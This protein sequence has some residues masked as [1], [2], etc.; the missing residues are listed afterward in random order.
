ML[1]GWDDLQRTFLL[2][3]AVTEL[4][5]EACFGCLQHFDL[6]RKGGITLVEH[7]N[8]IDPLFQILADM[9]LLQLK[10]GKLSPYSLQCSF[11]GIYL[12]CPHG[13]D[14]KLIFR[15]PI[16]HC[17]QDRIFHHLAFD[18]LS[19]A[20]SGGALVPG[21]TGAA[22]P[23]HLP[24]HNCTALLTIEYTVIPEGAVFYIS[25]HRRKTVAFTDALRERVRDTVQQLEEIRRNFLIPP[26][27]SG[28]KCKRCSLR[29]LC[30]PDAVRTALKYCD[31]LAKEAMEVE[32]P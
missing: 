27:V 15:Q 12:R 29:E 2:R 28:P 7:F 4:F 19:V 24:L 6:L 9:V 30:L 14:L 26:A 11:E 31:K 8:G 20:P 5:H 17:F 18:H 22:F 10:S 21:N 3:I 23:R 32:Y 25:S 1:G 16:V 13:I